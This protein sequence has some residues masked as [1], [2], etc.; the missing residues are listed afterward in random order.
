MCHGL[1]A[2]LDFFGRIHAVYLWPYFC[3]YFSRYR[4]YVIWYKT[5]I[6]IY[7]N[8]CVYIICDSTLIFIFISYDDN[9]RGNIIFFHVRLVPIRPV[10]RITE[11]VSIP[12]RRTGSID[13]PNSIPDLGDFFSLF[14]LSLSLFVQFLFRNLHFLPRLNRWQ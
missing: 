5:Y 7:R 1:Y 10:T 6:Y 11:D 8:V 2:W 13:F 12:I 14:S 3:F 9:T 4:Q